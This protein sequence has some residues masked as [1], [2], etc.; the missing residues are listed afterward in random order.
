MKKLLLGVAASATLIAAPAL[1]AD[2]PLKAP[3]P[4]A[5]VAYNWTGLYIGAN[6]GWVSENED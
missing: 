6:A 2:M 3:A 5:V 1:A 4:A